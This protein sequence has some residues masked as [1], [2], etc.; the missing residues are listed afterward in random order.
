MRKK[1][2]LNQQ[3]RSEQFCGKIELDKS[4]FVGARKKNRERGAAGKV[5]VFS[6]LKRGAKVYTQVISNAKTSTLMPVIREK[7]V[8]DSIV[9]TDCY[10]LYNTLDVFEF[11]H[12][13]IN[14]SELFCV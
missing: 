13:R 14:Y 5:A 7:L 8:P 12:F 1:L 2:A 9:Y 10:R 3:N 6:I 11:K 4:Y